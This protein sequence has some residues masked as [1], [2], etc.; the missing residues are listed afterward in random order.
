MPSTGFLWLLFS[1]LPL[2]MLTAWLFWW[3]RGR[4]LA[5]DK[6]TA[7][8]QAP[9]EL[10]DLRAQLM[11]SKATAKASEKRVLDLQ[12][13]MLTHLEAHGN[14]DEEAD[15]LRAALTEKEKELVAVNREKHDLSR[16]IS[17]LKTRAS[18]A[19]TE[20][21]TTAEKL[22]LA[23]T[24]AT[25]L[26]AQITSLSDR[27]AEKLELATLT[28]SLA[29]HET[30][31][32]QRESEWQ[33]E[34]TTLQQTVERQTT[35]L[36]AAQKELEN[37]R[38]EITNKARSLGNNEEKAQTLQKALEETKQSL[39]AA[40]TEVTQLK[41]AIPTTAAELDTLKKDLTTAT[42][43]HT[44]LTADLTAARLKADTAAQELE[45][46][47]STTK[48]ASELTALTKD[49]EA[50]EQ[51]HR[52]ALA[53][54]EAK[55]ATLTKAHSQETTTRQTAEQELQKLKST[56]KPASDYLHLQKEKETAEQK[57]REAHAAL[58]ARIAA[59]SHT[60]AAEQSEKAAAL[61]NYQ[62]LEAAQKAQ[63]PSVPVV[64]LASQGGSP[65]DKFG[66]LF[67]SPPPRIDDLKLIIGVGEVFE[68]KLNT[69]GVYQFAQM[70]RWDEPSA[71]EFS[72]NVGFPG[73]AKR[74]YWVEQC[75]Y[76]HHQK[77]QETL[78]S[79]E[80]W[81]HHHEQTRTA[82]N[83]SAAAFAPDIQ[84]GMATVDAR[85]GAL[86]KQRPEKIDDLKD[87]AGVAEIFEKRLHEAGIYRF[88]QIAL[89]TEETAECFSDDLG[90]SGRAGRE[91]WVEQ[92]RKLHHHH[93]QEKLGTWEKWDAAVAAKSAKTNGK[94]K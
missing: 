51:K 68:K 40:Q 52:D 63:N 46:L 94:A 23:L 15:N 80:K 69:E 75:R 78:G 73:R 27:S 58:E 33:T 36:T 5:W 61:S 84:A 38:I 72:K 37:H 6:P 7:P 83:A 22:T 62:A 35:A 21:D 56:T 41:K 57:H 9:G 54:L 70:A 90:F 60:L 79:W 43:K 92:C 42:A 12:T 49:K 77:Y 89:W 82:V 87:I 88:K 24:N 47:K 30:T 25:T 14:R 13:E 11:N 32:S 81:Q 20:R 67:Q 4:C 55:L 31:R 86:Y 71:E 44:Q 85:Y 16:S 1:I 17:E 10:I 34:R 74:E 26:K 93:Y 18:Q 50:A 65:K 39:T 2:I 59:L 28:Q 3:L 91:Y 76:L 64:S 19:E 45:K 66:I 48:P 29:S 8:S 53:A